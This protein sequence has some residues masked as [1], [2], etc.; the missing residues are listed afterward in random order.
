MVEI[1]C[2]VWKQQ[3]DY[4]FGKIIWLKYNPKTKLD[5]IIILCWKENNVVVFLC[6]L[7]FNKIMIAVEVPSIA[8]KGKIYNV[9]QKHCL[10]LKLSLM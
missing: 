4:L 10:N 1:Y 8:N 3:L 7:I 6:V 9:Q 2:I 5:N